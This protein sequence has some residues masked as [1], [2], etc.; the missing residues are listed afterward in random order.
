MG[1]WAM[2]VETPEHSR[3]RSPIP[4]ATSLACYSIWK[5]DVYAAAYNSK[6]HYRNTVLPCTKVRG[7]GV[8]DGVLHHGCR[9]KLRS[10]VANGCPY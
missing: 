2:P 10:I 8:P 4:K 5:L 9:S 3:Q 7:G 6:I 1:S